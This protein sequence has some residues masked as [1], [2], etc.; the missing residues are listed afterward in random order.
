MLHAFKARERNC[1]APVS[2]FPSWAWHASTQALVSHLRHLLRVL[3]LGPSE[4]LAG[5]GLETICLC[6]QRPLVLSASAPHSFCSIPPSGAPRLLSHCVGH[7]WGEE[8]RSSF[9]SLCNQLGLLHMHTD[10]E[11][12]V[13]DPLREAFYQGLMSYQG[14]IHR[15]RAFWTGL[16]G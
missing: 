14:I 16:T 7:V 8:P 2:G 6:A 1:G 11:R 3:G 13:A 15:R 9:S 4:M 5:P 10:H 12:A